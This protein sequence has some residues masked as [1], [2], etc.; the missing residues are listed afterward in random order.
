MDSILKTDVT[1][2]PRSKSGTL[3]ASFFFYRR[4]DPLQYSALGLFRSLL[5][6]MLSQDEELLASFAANTKFEERCKNE[7]E[8]GPGKKWD[9]S[10]SDL[11]EHVKDFTRKFLRNRCLRLYI[12][13][14]DESGETGARELWHYLK[15]LLRQN[16]GRL[17]GIPMANRVARTTWVPRGAFFRHG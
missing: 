6:Q 2:D 7:G 10:E 15:V 11:Q 9:W 12:D 13:A 1:Q 14:L 4:G 5:H 8:P 17:V 16:K 3:V